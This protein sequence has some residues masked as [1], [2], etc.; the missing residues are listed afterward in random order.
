MKLITAFISIFISLQVYASTY[1]EIKKLH[2]SENVDI[3]SNEKNNGVDGVQIKPVKYF[4]LSNGKKINTSDW[5]IVLFMQSSCPYCMQFDPILDSFAEENGFHV[6]PYTIDGKGDR[7]YPEPLIANPDVM[8]KFF[9]NIPIA[10]P[11]T[12]LINVN[13]L[14]AFPLI[15]GATDERGFINRLDNVFQIITNN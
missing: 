7:T 8:I 5:G 10:T 4:S 6:Y 15:Q 9:P 14:E 2:H 13:T 12:F 1:D 3:V 11:T